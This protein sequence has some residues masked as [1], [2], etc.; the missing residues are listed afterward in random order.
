[1]LKALELAGFKSFADKTRFEFVRGITAVVGPNG[2][3]KSNVVDAIKW[4]LGEQSVRSL[5]GKEM[6]DVIF[7][8][9]GSRQGV[10]AAEASLM[11]DNSAGGLEIDAVEVQITRRVY[12]SGEGEYLI[13]RQPC[14][15]RD[16][17]DLLSGTGVG[18]EAYSI[19]EQGKVDMML[20]ASPRDRRA[21]FEEAAGISRFKAKK[22]ETLRRLERVEQNLLRLSDIVDE[23]EN[24]LRSVRMQASKARRYKEHADRLQEL[25]TQVGHADWRRLS[26]QLAVLE[27]ELQGLAD[28][29]AA[30]TNEAETLE[31]QALEL[32]NAVAEAAEAIR[33]SEAR[34]AENRERIAKQES[35][36]DHE[37][38]RV[39]DAEE[40]TSRYLRQL[41]ALS[42]RA[43]DLETQLKETSVAAAKAEEEY[44]AE[45]WQLAEAEAGLAELSGQVDS[46]RSEYEVRRA[47]ALGATRAAA[48]LETEVTALASQ[49]ESARAAAQ[50]CLRQ[51]EELDRAGAALAEE[52]EQLRR[53]QQ[54]LTA[55]ARQRQAEW[56]VA[57]QRAAELREQLASRLSELGTLRLRHSGLT[58]RAALLAE[59]EQRQEGLG[60]GV[61]EVLERMRGESAFR[62]LRGLVAELFHVSVEMAPLVELALGERTQYFVAEVDEDW[63]D[64]LAEESRRLTGRVGF[65]R[66][67]GDA[68]STWEQAVDLEGQPGV[69]GR[70]DHF[71]DS[72]AP[73]APLVKRLLG[74][75]WIV[76]T[77]AHARK[78][79]QGLGRGMT[80]VT[81][82][83]E[84]L[85]PDGTISVGPREGAAGLISRRSELRALKHQLAELA[86]RIDSLAETAAALERDT[87]SE[88]QRGQSLAIEHQ[89]AADALAE[90]R[91][92]T[93]A[94]ETRRQQLNQQLSRLDAEQRTAEQRMAG[95]AETM[96]AVRE[97]LEAAQARLKD[98]E[99]A[100]AA[101]AARIVEV[102]R[103]RGRIQREVT[104]AK[105]ELAKSE[106][107]LTNLRTRR[108]QFEQDQQ[109]RRRSIL[110]CRQHLAQGRRR[111]QLAQANILNAESQLAELYLL[112]ET[113]AEETIAALERRELQRAARA[114]LM[115]KVQ[116]VRSAMRKLE[117][118][119]HAKDLAANEVRH[120]RSTLADRLRDDYQIELAQLEH[121][122]SD[123]ELHRREETDQEIAEL[124]RK[125]NNIGNVNLDALAELEEL[126]SRFANLSEQFDDLSRAKEAL[127]QIINKINADSRRLFAET[128]D[129]VKANFQQ[130]FRKLFGGGQADIVMDEGVDILDSGIE[131]VARPPGKE[132][133]SISLLSGGEKT[134]TC[135]ALLLAIFQ[136][137]PSPFCVLDEVDAALDEANIE[138]FIGVLQ[139]FLAWTQFIVVTHSKKTMTCAST[140][141]GVTMQESGVSK[142][143]SVRFEDVSDDGEIRS[144]ANSEAA[145]D[146]ETQAA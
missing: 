48:G 55:E 136:Y 65:I 91:S 33:S 41:A 74:R 7:N 21:L 8:G 3:G 85:T 84:L 35:T 138:R 27:Q 72:A 47:D 64:L 119:Q 117:E 32:E 20:Q 95:H 16:I 94:A 50:E 57:K 14:R 129:A 137:R 140:L 98:S 25:R 100:G 143:V 59:L 139:E 67:S 127:V 81:Q 86:A 144:P 104:A 89:R 28:R 44:A 111:A 78:L 17:R 105:V 92:Q 29:H 87:E 106:E 13:N 135:V 88:A 132:P 54:E 79:S 19:I 22:I 102:E 122:P 4:V 42:I 128:L 5:R 124:R 2:S 11:L 12:R 49:V 142:R 1:M 60:A 121:A 131:I 107:R 43:G 112:K 123:E 83:G 82:S 110:E 76:E 36:V 18:S 75:T 52:E 130:L 99:A 80:F 96:T 24:R 103:R 120:E 126:E 63:F 97:R 38:A 108:N 114:E 101:V 39:H 40:E 118:Q 10:N 90:H 6:A 37:R 31:A 23:V 68:S 134:L 109:E 141:Y 58:E 53:R 51:R 125:L 66:L 69:R 34:L 15:L 113:L 45:A 70:A 61:K 30:A 146:D 93:S 9:S 73:L 26:D 71:V 46:L 62:R 133:R 145:D 56:T 77:L 116:A 115:T